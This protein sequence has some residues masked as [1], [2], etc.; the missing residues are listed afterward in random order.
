MKRY[1]P[2][3]TP[4]T[5][6]TKEYDTQNFSSTFLEME[7]TVDMREPGEEVP[8]TE[9]EDEE[10]QREAF[11][12]YSF[13]TR[14][15]GLSAD[16]LAADED[17]ESPTFEGTNLPS[18][19]SSHSLAAPTAE[20]PLPS[21]GHTPKAVTHSESDLLTPIASSHHL[22]LNHEQEPRASSQEGV[23]RADGDI[24]VFVQNGDPGEG[25]DDWERVEGTPG[26]EA[27][28]GNRANTLFA[29]GVVD[30]YKLSVL[31]RKDS[32]LRRSASTLRMGSVR[33]SSG[34][35]ELSKSSSRLQLRTKLRVKPRH[36]KGSTPPPRAFSNSV[37]RSDSGLSTNNT[38]SDTSA[39][40]SPLVSP[41]ASNSSIPPKEAIARG[42]S[43]SASAASVRSVSPVKGSK[44]SLNQ[45]ERRGVRH[46][47]TSSTEA[48]K[49]WIQKASPPN[50]R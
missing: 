33:R 44:Q 40:S 34:P 3:Y 26:G 18:I 45:E 1:I 19:P 13:A 9:P 43:L 21:A 41:T 27:P 38:P 16:E 31:K 42:P 25:E 7:A 30:R 4:E 10:Q 5:D 17:D 47:A 32:T 35:E 29:R 23:R 2:P 48:L 6:A 28:N 49:S 14:P 24:E 8:P 20:S 46:M 11:R 39:A 22:Q 12:T 15:L 50:D 36:S 37:G